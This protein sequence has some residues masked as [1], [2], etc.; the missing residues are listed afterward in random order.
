VLNLSSV[1]TTISISDSYLTAGLFRILIF[2][3]CFWTDGAQFSEQLGPGRWHCARPR[4]ALRLALVCPYNQITWMSGIKGAT[5]IAHLAATG[6]QPPARGA[7]LAEA[8][9]KTAPGGENQEKRQPDPEVTGPHRPARF[10]WSKT[11]SSS[12]LVG[13]GACSRA[14]AMR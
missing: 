10:F 9:E 2:W 14:W 3:S 4:R 12:K 8:M 6:A 11:I 13:Q 5:A 7:P 1:R